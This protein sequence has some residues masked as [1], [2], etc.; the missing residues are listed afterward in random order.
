M[1]GAQP[2]IRGHEEGTELDRRGQDRDYDNE[3][4]ETAA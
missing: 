3:I 1:I 2:Q 4:D